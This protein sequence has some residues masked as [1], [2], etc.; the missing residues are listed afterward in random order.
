MLLSMIVII[1]LV[2]CPAR[3]L[4]VIYNTPYSVACLRSPY[5]IKNTITQIIRDRLK[6]SGTSL[7]KLGDDPVITK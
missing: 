2:W 7:H 5:Q 1:V 4:K 3:I 6:F